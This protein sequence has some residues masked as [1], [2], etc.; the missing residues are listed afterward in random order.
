MV[1]AAA[2]QCSSVTQD[3]SKDAS[4]D[5]SKDAMQDS[6]KGVAQ[7]A[8]GKIHGVKDVS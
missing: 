3:S 2:V 5:S 8:E 1:V 7:D 4:Q 6:S